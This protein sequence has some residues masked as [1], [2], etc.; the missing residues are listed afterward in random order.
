MPMKSAALYHGLTLVAIDILKQSQKV[1]EESTP[2]GG[3]AAHRDITEIFSS[4]ASDICVA[5][6]ADLGNEMQSFVKYTKKYRKR[7]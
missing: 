3:I 2:E 1:L 7:M 6:A 5:E 4:L